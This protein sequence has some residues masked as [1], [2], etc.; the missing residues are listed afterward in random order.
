[1]FAQDWFRNT[2]MIHKTILDKTLLYLIVANSGNIILVAKH[3]KD[4]DSNSKC[5]PCKC[6]PDTQDY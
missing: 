1:M 6:S 5:L 4:T 2:F 3:Y